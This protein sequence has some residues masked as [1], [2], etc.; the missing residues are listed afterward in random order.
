MLRHG[1]P[2]VRTLPTFPG[3]DP[4][5]ANPRFPTSVTP[6]NGCGVPTFRGKGGLNPQHRD[7]SM[8]STTYGNLYPLQTPLP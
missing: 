7:K 6:W 5:R 3:F 2:R 8:K 1:P 4:L